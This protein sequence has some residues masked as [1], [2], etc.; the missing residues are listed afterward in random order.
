VPRDPLADILAKKSADL[1]ET[2]FR[3]TEGPEKLVAD[4][5]KA[6]IRQA[7]LMVDGKPGPSGI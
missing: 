2:V 7:G 1:I 3:A 6:T 4:K 5:I